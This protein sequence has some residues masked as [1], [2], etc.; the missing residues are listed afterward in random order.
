MWDKILRWL[1]LK[2]ERPKVVIVGIWIKD[3]MFYRRVTLRTDLRTGEII[4]QVEKEY[5]VDPVIENALEREP[6]GYCWRKDVWE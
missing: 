6:D 4:A 2:K 1:G 3:G 5:R